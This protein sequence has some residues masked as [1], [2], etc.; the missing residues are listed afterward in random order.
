[1]KDVLRSSRA[2]RRRRIGV[3]LLS[4]GLLAGGTA[5]VGEQANAALTNTSR[6]VP[7]SPTRILDTRNDVVEASDGPKDFVGAGG[8]I[9]LQVTGR[10]GVPVDATAVSMNLTA[11]AAAAPGFVTMWPTGEG[12]P[13]ASNLNIER[14]GQ[15]IA[16]LSVVRLGT[17]GAVNLFT[18]GGAHLIGDVS[19]Y[20]VPS[21]AST[22]GRLIPTKPTRIVD[23]R[24]G[25][26]VPAG[27]V[28]KDGTITSSLSG[29][30]GSGYSAAVLNVT[31]TESA[32][33]GFVTV[34]PSGQSRPTVSN[35]N[36]ERADQTI[37]NL[38]IVR[39]GDGGGINF[40]SQNGTQLIADLVAVFTDNSGALN[41]QGLFVPQS[42]NRIADSRKTLGFGP[43]GAGGSATLTVPGDPAD[44]GA[45]LANVTATEASGKGYVTVWPGDL[46]QPDSSNLN[47]DRV[48][49]TIPNLVISGV[50]PTGTVNLF[51]Q[52]G[53]QL[54]VDLA[55]VFTK[56]PTITPTPPKP[57]DP[58]P[59]GNAT[60]FKL[61]YVWP[62]NVAQP[63]TA[64][65]GL[66]IKHEVSLFQDWLK[67]KA[68]GRMLRM[69]GVNGVP[70]VIAY[71]LGAPST[72]MSP[73]SIYDEAVSS[74]RIG[75]NEYAFFWVQAAYTGE[76]EDNIPKKAGFIWLPTCGNAQPSASSAFPN[77]AAMTAAEV[78][79]QV[80]GV[81]DSRAP[82]YASPHYLTAAANHNDLFY[83]GGDRQ[84]QNLGL[85]DAHTDY[86][87]HGNPGYYDLKNDPIWQAA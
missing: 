47:L 22:D 4:L 80:L 38:V 29:V 1:M 77:F 25:T 54:I 66:A 52:S 73:T 21:S 87:G 26:G 30:V 42:P 18:Q 58:P 3:G 27:A 85:D 49:Q 19:G 14:A 2:T 44:F 15:T 67:T 83:E 56:S 76:C 78:M 39:L 32:N 34:W 69:V 51:S 37:P 65:V 79:L 36:L 59:S 20:W 5:M 71:G 48:N 6:F 84:I 12:I 10:G 68:G 57:T 35:L 11:T 45:I 74:G 33:A 82:H 46:G 9:T 86:Y 17:G 61:F 53:T 50:S 23:T 55:G 7:L 75:A 31:A 72:Q 70:D 24:D 81:V 41:A 16:N 28:P 40:Y 13:K 43:L 8:Q 60:S 62:S 64:A 63:D